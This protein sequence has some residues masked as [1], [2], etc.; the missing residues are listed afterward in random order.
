MFKLIDKNTDDSVE[1]FSYINQLGHPDTVKM[2]NHLVKLIDNF[3]E[4][5]SY[6]YYDDIPN[7]VKALKLAYIHR[8]G[9]PL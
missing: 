5:F 3:G 1:G 4:P 8:T 2:E 9:L 7:L 6:L